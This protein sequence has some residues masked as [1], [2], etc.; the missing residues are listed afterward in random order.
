MKN[1]QSHYIK[2]IKFEYFKSKLGNEM[3]KVVFYDENNSEVYRHF[4]V[5]TSKIDFLIQKSED[6]FKMILKDNDIFRCNLMD[7]ISTGV[8]C[9]AGF[10]NK[11]KN[12][13]LKKVKSIDV[14]YSGKYPNL[15]SIT[16]E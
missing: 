2:N 4:V 1:M 13:Y 6:F 16:F 9:A 14:D 15:K 11:H 5:V 10:L 12:T 7:A 3:I 8:E